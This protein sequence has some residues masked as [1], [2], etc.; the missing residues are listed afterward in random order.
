M[1]DVDPNRHQLEQVAVLNPGARSGLVHGTVMDDINTRASAGLVWRYLDE[2][3]HWRLEL[4]ANSCE[5]VAVKNGSRR[6]VAACD[7]PRTSVDPI[8]LQILDDGER[9]M[10]FVD[11]EPLSHQWIVDE[12]LQ[13]ATMVGVWFGGA[14][15]IGTRIERFEA[16]PLLVSLPTELDMGAPWFRKGDRI[17]IEDHFAGAAGDLEGRITST[18][19]ARWHRVIG[20]G[21]IETTGAGAARVRASVGAPAPGRT[22]YC[23]DSPNPDFVDLEVMVTPPASTD[24]DGHRT[25][26]GFVLYQ[27]AGNYVTQNAYRSGYYPGGSVSTFFKFGGYEDVYDAIWS[28]VGDRVRFGQPLRLRLCCDGERYVVLINDETVLFRAFRDVYPD[29]G[30]LRIRKVGIIA[31][32][33]FGADTGSIFEHFKLRG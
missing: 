22:A 18:G 19:G 23:I 31:N 1:A 29:I 9:Q 4:R 11:G 30:R 26:A 15:T 16:H 25:T 14:E 27:D 32:W 20:Q 28:N 12:Y 13:A 2:C 3:N 6:V 33:E 10:G 7:R 21:V 5:M 8:R 17:L 24:G